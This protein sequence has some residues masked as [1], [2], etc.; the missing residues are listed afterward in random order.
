MCIPQKQGFC[1]QLMLFARTKRSEA[2]LD[3]HHSV[4]DECDVGRKQAK[5]NRALRTDFSIQLEQF[6]RSAQEIWCVTVFN[7]FKCMH[8][9]EDLKAFIKQLF[10][11]NIPDIQDVDLLSEWAVLVD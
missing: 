9:E 4:G 3:E 5:P 10:Q 2:S 6:S 7:I 11:K 1:C 8:T